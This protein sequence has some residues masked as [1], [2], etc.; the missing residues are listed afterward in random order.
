MKSNRLK[1]IG[2]TTTHSE[3]AA[4]I[5]RS[6]KYVAF[7]Y[8]G[9]SHLS[10]WF[11]C[12]KLAEILYFSEHA[13]PSNEVE[14]AIAKAKHLLRNEDIRGIALAVLLPGGQIGTLISGVEDNQ[15]HE[16]SSAINILR[17]RFEREYMEWT[18]NLLS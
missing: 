10:L 13:G 11:W 12:L 7:F 14:R 2:I 1:K 6:I 4:S 17:V 16:M 15:F 9:Q 3:I 18:I 5:S 8:L